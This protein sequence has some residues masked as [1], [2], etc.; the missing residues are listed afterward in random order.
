MRASRYQWFAVAAVL[1]GIVVWSAVNQSPV[2]APGAI[3]TLLPFSSEAHAAD[4]S[5]GQAWPVARGD[6]F[7]TG[8]AESTLPD[9]LEVVWSYKA[10]G[11][12]FEGTPAIADGMAFIGDVGTGDDE[13]G[14]LFAF[15][16]KTGEIKWTFNKAKLGFVASPAYRDGKIYIGDGNGTFFCINA[17][18]GAELWSHPM[19]AEVVAGANFVGDKILVGC[20]DSNI[21]CL[22][23]SNGELLWKKPIANQIRT[24]TTSDKGKAFVCQCDGTMHIM[25][26]ESGG[27]DASITLGPPDKPEA[28][29]NSTPVVWKDYL[30]F[31]TESGTVM[32]LD[33]KKSEFPWTFNLSGHQ[34]FRSSP[35]VAEDIAVIGGR[36][37]V[38]VAIDPTTGKEKW[39]FPT[40][41][42]VDSSPV[43]VGKRVFIGGAD[44]RLYAL[45][46]NSG[47]ELWQHQGR[48][49]YKGS[50]AVADGKLVIA[51]DKGTVYCFGKK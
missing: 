28:N 51:T 16:L 42:P 24:F 47:K 43:I 19:E 36:A 44:G 1:L 27:I 26:I 12:G 4:A 38:V 15:D 5:R 48:G 30:I 23:A 9:K 46:R 6:V 2:A 22:N 37:K 7:G 31:G 35:A 17:K 32:A 39:K 3:A 41:A 13:T 34:A 49:E 11:T 25:D 50:P 14:K 10:E 45:D 33:W 29:L 20:Q 18:D 8:V 21:Y 40:K